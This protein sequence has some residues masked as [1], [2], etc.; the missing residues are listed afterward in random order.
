VKRIEES[1]YFLSE[2][3]HT[4]LG[5]LRIL[6]GC[7]S[8]EAVF[9]FATIIVNAVIHPRIENGGVQSSY[10]ESMACEVGD[11]ERVVVMAIVPFG[12]IN[13]ERKAGLLRRNLGAIACRSP[14][15]L[16]NP[17]KPTF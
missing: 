16:F 1:R 17:P 8:V 14:R 13:D 2:A 5:Q 3:S 4:V 9:R 12:Y 6:S 15:G 11:R 7:A 10:D